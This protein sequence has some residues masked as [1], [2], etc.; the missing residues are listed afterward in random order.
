MMSVLRCGALCSVVVVALGLGA[1]AEDLT[2]VN[3]S[4]ATVNEGWQ[5]TISEGAKANA[6]AVTAAKALPPVADADATGKDLKT[7]LDAALAAHK[8]A[9]SHL[10]QV[11][12]ESKGAVEKA[13]VEKKVLPVQAAIDA[14]VAKWA[15]LQPKLAPAA[16]AVGT[17]L[18]ALK[19]H[20]DA[21]AAKAAAAAADPANKDPET[22]KT[23]G[24]EASFAFAFDDKGGIDET[25]SAAVTDRLV[26]FLNSCE[27]LKVELTTGGADAK[28]AKSRAAAA[29]KLV[30]GKGVP[31][32]RIAKA[33]SVPAPD[34]PV[35]AKV[36]TPCPAAPATP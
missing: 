35:V 9:V 1:C 34:G 6:D 24:G 13:A 25:A 19:T 10:E 4:F 33:T 2:A 28:V 8:E 23:A 30:E 3:A 21:E 36:V 11:A 29:Q 14:G 5:K 7:K 26:K 17:S 31:A 27:A 16:A 32:G 15:T 22:V 18:T 20:L 12:V